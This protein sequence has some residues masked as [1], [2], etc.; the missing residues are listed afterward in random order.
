MWWWRKRRQLPATAV[1]IRTITNRHRDTHRNGEKQ[2]HTRTHTHTHAH[3]RTRT[4]TRTRTHTHTHTQSQPAPQSV[5]LQTWPIVS[6]DSERG[7]HLVGDI[8]F[9]AILPLQARAH[10]IHCSTW[11]KAQSACMQMLGAAK[12]ASKPTINQPG[13]STRPLIPK[14]FHVLLTFLYDLAKHLRAIHVCSLGSLWCWSTWTNAT[15]QE[16]KG[17]R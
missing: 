6:R 9:I 8:I 12:E 4:R 1:S 14:P 11:E 10:G 3:T 5:W 15:V 16:G 17:V 13:Q 2:T 7:R